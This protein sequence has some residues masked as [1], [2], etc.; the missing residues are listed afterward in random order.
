MNKVP[1]K[2]VCVGRYV[3]SL[4][5]GLPEEWSQEYN[6]YTVKRLPY[7]ISSEDAF[8]ALVAN[9][10]KELA[11]AKHNTETHLLSEF[12][13]MDPN[14][15]LLISRQGAIDIYTYN[16]EKYVWTGHWG[17]LFTK[18]IASEERAQ[19]D[20]ESDQSTGLVPINNFNHLPQAGFCVDEALV[21]AAL[22]HAYASVDA[23]IP[24]WKKSRI[25][26]TTAEHQTEEDASDADTSL[27]KPIWRTFYWL[28]NE[29][30]VFE[31][32]RREFASDTSD[33]LAPTELHVLR[34]RELILDG[35]QG[36]EA[37]WK[38]VNRRGD[39]TYRFEWDSIDELKNPDLSSLIIR[40][41][42]G[43]NHDPEIIQTPAESDLFSLWDAVLPTLHKR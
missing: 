22:D 26:F 34:R 33:A 39:V 21:I 43:S 28:D 19:V 18:G 35:R 27:S 38:M 37:V 1:L 41:D 15:W 5:Y 3:I 24:G 11:S 20:A 36:Q 29:K 32:V 12:R 2:P 9:R 31:E 13:Q 42:I 17:Y 7:D 25:F 23:Y 40:M 4:P 14:S 30:K 16:V 6:G 10:R 8:H